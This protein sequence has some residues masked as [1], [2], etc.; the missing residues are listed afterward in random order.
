MNVKNR[1]IGNMEL[2][3]C[4]H[5]G[6]S[7]TQASFSRCKLRVYGRCLKSAHKLL[8]IEYIMRHYNI[9]FIPKSSEYV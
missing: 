2:Y 4:L 6:S 7:L 9:S 5:N 1:A 8:S 3:F